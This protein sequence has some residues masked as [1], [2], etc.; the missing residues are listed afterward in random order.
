MPPLADAT[1][2]ESS[3]TITACESARKL[4][5]TWTLVT[6]RRTFSN[7]AAPLRLTLYRFACCAGARADHD[8]Q[9]GEHTRA[10]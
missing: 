4:M 7:S 6:R 1:V 5:A 3:A 10:V 2:C 8:L 9:G